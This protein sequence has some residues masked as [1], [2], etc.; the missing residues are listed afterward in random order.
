MAQPF[1]GACLLHAFGAGGRC[2]LGAWVSGDDR[3]HWRSDDRDSPQA[4]VTGDSSLDTAAVLCLLGSLWGGA[5]FH[6]AAVAALVLQLS[7]RDRDVACP[8]SFCLARCPVAGRP[9]E[10]IAAICEEIDAADHP[11]ADCFEYSRDD[12]PDSACAQGGAEQLDDSYWIRERARSP[13]A[14]LPQRIDNIDV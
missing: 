6:P 10:P 14:R 11:A 4:S 8:G 7:L 3:C 12:V 1:L 9:M 13:I 5:D 2:Y